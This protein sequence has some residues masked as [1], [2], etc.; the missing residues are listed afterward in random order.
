MGKEVRGYNSARGMC[1]NPKAVLCQSIITSYFCVMFPCKPCKPF[2]ACMQNFLAPQGAGDYLVFSDCFR[3]LSENS[4]LLFP[5]RMLDGVTRLQSQSNCPI[6]FSL[7][8]FLFASP[9]S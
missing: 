8:V 7:F 4:E 2:V 1:K 6:A 9:D 3:G 5:M